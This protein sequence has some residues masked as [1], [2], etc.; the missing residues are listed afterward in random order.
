MKHPN[1]RTRPGTGLFVRPLFFLFPTAGHCKTRWVVR[2]LLFL[3]L[4][5]GCG[6]SDPGVPHRNGGSPEDPLQGIV[7]FLPE[8]TF[9]A[10]FPPSFALVA[11]FPGIDRVP[12]AWTVFPAFSHNAAEHRVQV[13][14]QEGTSLYGTGEIAGPLLR[15][16]AVTQ[17]WNYDSWGYSDRNDHL[18]QSHPWVLAVRGDGSAFGVLADT[19]VRTRI[20][21]RDGISFSTERTPFP[22]I[23]IDAA[24]PQ[25][26]LKRLALLTGTMP[27]PPLWSLGYHQCRFSYTPDSKVRAIAD[28]F[29]TRSIPCDVIWMDI[30][31][32]DGY[33]VFTFDPQGFPDPAATNEYL[34]ENGFKAI[35]MIDPGVKKDPGY[36]VYDQG[37]AGNHW[38][39]TADGEEYNANVWP[40]PCAFPDF[41]RPETRAWWAGLYGDFMSHGIDGV[42]NDMNEPAIFPPL[43]ILGSKTMPEDNRHRGGGGLPPGPHALYHN[44]YGMLMIRATREGVQTANPDR[45]PFV[46]TRSNYIGGQ[47]YAATW[48][49]DNQATWNHL[50]WSVT[51]ILNLGLSGQPFSGP[52]I[53]GHEFNTTR[54]LF[55]RW[56]GV[57]ALFPFSRGHKTKVTFPH[58]PWSFGSEVEEIARTALERRYRLLPYLYTLFQ[59]ASTSGLPV[60]RPVFFADP[61]DPALRREDHSF[62]LG[63][64]LLVQP[65]LTEERE[66]VFPEPRGIWRAVTLVGE[67]PSREPDHPVLKIRGGSIVPLGRVVQNTTEPS[68]DPLTLV[69]SLDEEGRAE[70]VLYEDA[71]EGFAYRTGD[72]RLTT[73]EARAA[74][75]H[76]LVRI[77]SRQGALERPR[78]TV[79]VEL[80]TS[81]GVRTAEGDAT[82]GIEVPFP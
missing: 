17:T 8:G 71:G 43:G 60:M 7:R 23:V 81:A 11:P 26:V 80:I 40:G 65:Q 67:D 54:E 4:A 73:Y 34:H 6:G 58:E 24:S 3:L 37:S 78:R 51:M 45:R 47:R 82:R 25:E 77:R 76:V 31:Y 53:G 12:D 1:R 46:L 69:V 55:A 70:G 49:G 72:Y 48:T 41:T 61:A 39:K 13:T 64:C 63:P 44:V 52:D 56:I 38:V 33:R 35:W 9:P 20:D 62:L 18:Y 42:W 5:A 14:V 27:L 74:G 68:L 32:M 28:G 75:G 22:V 21:L 16:G 2:S 59:E 30:D 29:R 50:R 57:G 10:S 79:R 66:H 36:F 15:N 19:T